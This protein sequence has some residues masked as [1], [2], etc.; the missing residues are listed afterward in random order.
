MDNKRDNSFWILVVFFI[1]Y[2]VVALTSKKTDL[3]LSIA[4]LGIFILT[5]IIGIVSDLFGLAVY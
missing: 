1:G 4:H 5:L 3:Y 2:G